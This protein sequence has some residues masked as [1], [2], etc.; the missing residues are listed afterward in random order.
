[1]DYFCK[2]GE[3]DGVI[4]FRAICPKIDN[5]KQVLSGFEAKTD[6]D[7]YRQLT[8]TASQ[9][10]EI[11]QETLDYLS[12]HENISWCGLVMLAV[13]IENDSKTFWGPNTEFVNG[14]RQLIRTKSGILK[15]DRDSR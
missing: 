12:V 5:Y 7:S 6:V 2:A 1:M 9:L 8:L 15:K 11:D 14:L 4:V 3:K 10:G 13:V